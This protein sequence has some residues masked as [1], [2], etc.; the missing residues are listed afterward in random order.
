MEARLRNFYEERRILK[1]SKGG[2]IPTRRNRNVPAGRR[3]TCGGN[4]GCP[5][6]VQPEPA[7]LNSSRLS[8]A[9]VGRGEGEAADT[10]VLV[11]FFRCQ[12]TEATRQYCWYLMLQP[13]LLLAGD[14]LLFSSS[15]PFFLLFPF[16][17]R[18]LLFDFFFLFFFFAV[19]S[20]SSSIFVPFDFFLTFLFFKVG[21]KIHTNY[22]F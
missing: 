1:S 18:F 17:T 21:L 5:R 10:G 14:P 16:S 4:D 12:R 15:P 6:T 2:E 22:F 20:S 7:I 3:R 11:L 19:V 13:Y 8:A 9:G